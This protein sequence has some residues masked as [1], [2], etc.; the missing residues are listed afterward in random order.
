MRLSVP[1]RSRTKPFGLV[2]YTDSQSF[3]LPHIYS[4]SFSRWSALENTPPPI[5]ALISY[6]LPHREFSYLSFADVTGFRIPSPDFLNG[7]IIRAPTMG[8]RVFVFL[9]KRRGKKVSRI[10]FS[11]PANASPVSQVTCCRNIHYYWIVR[12]TAA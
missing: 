5:T 8:E 9:K 7:I 1:L 12:T 6:A 11:T 10:I 3:F 4:P 2:S